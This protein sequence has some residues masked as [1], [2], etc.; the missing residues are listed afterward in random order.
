MV[1]LTRRF[2]WKEGWVRCGIPTQL[3]DSGKISAT[4]HKVLPQVHSFEGQRQEWLAVSLEQ[5]LRKL[6]LYP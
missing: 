1:T 6:L 3:P 4:L 2:S 5:A